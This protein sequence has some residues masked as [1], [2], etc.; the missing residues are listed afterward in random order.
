MCRDDAKGVLGRGCKGRCEAVV[1]DGV[2]LSLSGVISL[3]LTQTLGTCSDREDVKGATTRRWAQVAQRK[4]GLETLRY[5]VGIGGFGLGQWPADTGPKDDV[6]SEQTPCSRQ[7]WNGR[8]G[9]APK[10]QASETEGGRCAEGG[11]GKVDKW[12][13]EGEANGGEG[14]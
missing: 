9:Q 2:F 5:V 4:A 7:R 11:R 3:T 13:K 8:A 14:E 6:K 10:R 12:P 1:C